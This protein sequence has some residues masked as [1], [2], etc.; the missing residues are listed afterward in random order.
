MKLPDAFCVHTCGDDAHYFVRSDTGF[1]C[2][3]CGLK[4]PWDSQHISKYMGSAME[5]T[6]YRWD[7][8]RMNPDD[9][10][11]FSISA[12]DRPVF[13][14]SCDFTHLCIRNCLKGSRDGWMQPHYP[15]DYFEPREIPLTD[16][17]RQQL[18]DLLAGFHFSDW[19]TPAYYVENTH[20]PG[21][22]VDQSFT[23]TFSEHERFAC[24]KP[25]PSEFET[26]VSLIRTIA[27]TNASS[28]DRDFVNRMLMDTE[29]QYKQIYWLISQSLE[30]KWA[31]L[32]AEGA[33]FFNYMVSREMKRG[34]NANAE[35]MVNVIRFSKGA[36]WVTE[37]G[38]P[39]KNYQWEHIPKESGNDLGAAFT[40]L[41]RHFEAIPE[42]GR[43]LFPI[44]A[45]VLDG[46]I[47]DDWLAAQKRFHSL[48]GVD[49][50]VLP[51][52]LVMGNKVGKR[53]EK[54]FNGVTYYINSMEDIIYELD[55]PFFGF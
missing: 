19:E 28:A 38:I 24:L 6:Y 15:E 43:K 12:G 45:L 21:F 25:D 52:A 51:I 55:S 27:R 2:E 37:K 48:P 14:A 36:A 31:D 23:C 54:N 50:H 18:R 4:L 47:T 3:Y 41:T 13:E 22:A 11:S 30:E 10:V 44:V 39:E 32:I 33:P 8:R 7:P 26:L 29:K 53:F 5:G 34:D 17:N 40:L 46:P 35:L 1:L 20:A 42:P 16:K 49:K 9:M